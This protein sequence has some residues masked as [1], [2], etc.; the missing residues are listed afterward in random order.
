MCDQQYSRSNSGTHLGS[1]AGGGGAQRTLV[2]DPLLH[3]R[4][5]TAPAVPHALCLLQSS[6]FFFRLA[7]VW[8]QRV[9]ATESLLHDTTVESICDVLQSLRL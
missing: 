3:L 2:G 8:Q 1:L 6:C 9:G 7:S 5:Q 4:R